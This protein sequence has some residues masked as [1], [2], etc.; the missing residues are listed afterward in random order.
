VRPVEDTLQVIVRA[1]GGTPVRWRIDGPLEQWIA[2]SA[3]ELAP[4]AHALSVEAG[5]RN[6]A[7]TIAVTHDPGGGVTRFVAQARI[8]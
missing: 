3:V 7:I 4:G 2:P 5:D 8:D 1:L 6:A